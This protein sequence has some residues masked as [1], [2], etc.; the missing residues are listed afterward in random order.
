MPTYRFFLLM[1]IIVFCSNISAQNTFQ[2]TYGTIN[3]NQGNSV[4]ITDDGNYAVAGWYDASGLFSAE[5]YLLL[6]DTNGD[7]LWTRTYGEKADT[8]ANGF[9]L[10][11]NG[12]EGH[13]LIQTSD[14]G[15]LFVGE[16]HEIGGGINSTSD[17][18][19][20]KIDDQGELEW[21]RLYGAN[22]NEYGYAA[23]QTADDEYVIGGFAE[24]IGAGLRDMLLFKT[25][26]FGDTLWTKIYGGFTID[27][28]QDLQ[29]TPEGGYILAGQ[30]FSYGAGDSDVFII[31][32]DGQGDVIWQKAYGGSE[33][34]LANSIA[35]TNDGGYIIAGEAESFGA[36][37]ADCYLLKID[38]DG[39]LEWSKVFGGDNFDSAKSV[40]QTSD[41]GYI[42]TG[43]TRS[44]GNGGE[45]FYLIKTDEQG[46]YLWAK[47]FG[48]NQ[49][50]TAQSIKQ[51]TDNGYILTGYTRSFGA[52]ANDVFLV[53]T[54]SMGNSECDQLAEGTLSE[55]PNTIETIANAITNQGLPVNQRPTI[56]GFTS[57]TILDD[58]CIDYSSTKE[59]NTITIRLSPN[60]TSDFLTIESN[61]EQLPL[62]KEA[63]IYDVLGQTVFSTTLNNTSE[64]I[65]VSKL[66]SGI[67]FLSIPVE[68][69]WKVHRFVKN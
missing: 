67:F 43:Y 18:F 44:F 10:N 7:T 39:N 38:S 27:A 40:V 59:N 16:R 19:V 65:D 36:G 17:A 28:A 3:G 15:F 45:D 64:R 61:D 52:G 9:V 37:D 35:P 46:N 25:N 49:D 30:T 48:G 56:S 14:G 24:D 42:L 54:D 47:T 29:A 57:T 5:F 1:L 34:D 12:N 51:T 11:G 33:F 21:S 63:I 32:T 53:K 13:N 8:S 22:E 68:G 31:K 26:T 2:K 55:T 20:V 62:N 6:L 66:S 41:G 4:I 58:P 69:G 50:E 60:P 23:V